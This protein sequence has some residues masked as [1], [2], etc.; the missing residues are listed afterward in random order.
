MVLTYQQTF[1]VFLLG[2]CFENLFD[3]LLQVLQHFRYEEGFDGGPVN[4]TVSLSPS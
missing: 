4:H 1:I 3:N 2:Y